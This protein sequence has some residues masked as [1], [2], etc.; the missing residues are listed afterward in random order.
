MK[1][2]Y[3]VYAAN[4]AGGAFITVAEDTQDHISVHDYG[5][6]CSGVLKHWG[7]RAELIK[8]LEGIIRAI[9]ELPAV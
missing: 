2:I 8:E 9:N 6:P 3:T 1:K 5:E 4:K 7:T